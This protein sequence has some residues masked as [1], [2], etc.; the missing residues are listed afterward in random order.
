MMCG[1]YLCVLCVCCGCLCVVYT[2]ILC[3]HICCMVCCTYDVCV[4]W[5]VG[6]YLCCCAPVCCV[7]VMC[8]ARKPCPTGH[9]LRLLSHSTSAHQAESALA[10][11]SKG[12]L[13]PPCLS[14]PPGE[15]TASSVHPHL[16]SQTQDISSCPF[17]RQAAFVLSCLTCF[18]VWI[19]FR[20]A[21]LAVNP[22]FRLSSTSQQGRKKTD[23]C[24]CPKASQGPP[25]PPTHKP[26]S[27][28]EG[29]QI[30]AK[31]TL[32]SQKLLQINNLGD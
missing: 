3:A 18:A 22:T 7:S 16:L 20:G 24:A 1:L 30:K 12:S 25:V 26:L 32:F 9:S 8:C 10:S 4:V 11:G 2:W 21:V 28:V 5:C 14:M 13:G 23:R 19:C 6:V 27:L 17:S 15:M 29:Q 31:G